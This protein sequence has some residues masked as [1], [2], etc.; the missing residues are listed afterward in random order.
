MLVCP[1]CSTPVQGLPGGE[2]IGIRVQAECQCGRLDA[3]ARPGPGGERR[4]SVRFSPDPFHRAGTP[5]I[6][7]GGDGSAPVLVTE[8][9][10]RYMPRCFR[11]AGRF[12]LSGA[13]GASAVEALVGHSLALS[14]L[15]T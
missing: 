8:F 13:R 6:V 15:S 2:V 14:V 4:T 7:C 9:P 3:T 10:H 11:A 5:S 1:V 12:P